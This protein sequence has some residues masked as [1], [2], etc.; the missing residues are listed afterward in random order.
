MVGEGR[1]V[2]IHKTL[3][4]MKTVSPTS[5]HKHEFGTKQ[6]FVYL[7]VNVLGSSIF[8]PVMY[9]LHIN[10][11]N[12]IFFFFTIMFFILKIKGKSHW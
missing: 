10:Y 6:I 5:L 11:H 7:Y 12:A 4:D 9:N 2:K 1:K 8:F 3:T